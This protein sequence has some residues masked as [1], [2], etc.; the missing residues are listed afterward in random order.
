MKLLYLST[1]FTALTHTFI[2]REINQLRRSGCEIGLLSLRTHSG[3]SGAARPECDLTGMRRIYPVGPLRVLWGVARA[4]IG[5]PRRFISA[6]GAC[7][8]SRRDSATT[9]LKL[10]YQL[11]VATTVAPEI[12]AQGY[13]HIHAHF[14]SS[15]AT[16]ALLISELTGVPFSF[17]GH[18]AD[19][20]R[21]E[22][23]L[24]TKLRRAAGVVCIS[25]Y[26]RRHFHSLV[27]DLPPTALVRC[28]IDSGSV[29]C[30]RRERAGKPLDVLAVGR[31]VPKKGFAV[32]IDALAELDRRGV[33]W[34]AR[35]VG[36]GPLAAEL[37]ARTDAEGLKDLD[38]AGGMQQ[39]EIRSLM[40]KA[41]VFALPCVVAADG[42]RDNIPVSLMEAMA[43]GCPVISTDVAA[44]PELI[45]DGAGLTVPQ[46]DA[47]ALAD[48]LQTIADD[49]RTVSRLSAAGRQKIETDFDLI[50]EGA[51]L[52]DF[53][54][55]LQQR[56]RDVDR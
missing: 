13:D 19:I 23:A 22:S 55:R 29:A 54:R 20:F 26:N 35:I 32:L 10:L 17:T 30:Y 46:G 56:P 31:L 48:A 41:D 47:R 34:R 40:E 27:A 2:T 16:F 1:S 39:N 33:A 52:L 50:R 44:I 7:L 37:R 45:G 6:M 25:E 12:E 4:L 53:F 36:E 28:G 14:A 5:R 24:D 51:K 15:P 9:K 3:C 38:F 43:A 21:E 42:D 49:S 18:A 11:A 8:A